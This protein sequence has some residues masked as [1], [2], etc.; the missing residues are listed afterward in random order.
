MFAATSDLF[1]QRMHWKART[2][3]VLAAYL[4]AA[5]LAAPAAA[6]P[7]AEALPADVVMRALSLLDVPYRYGGR[8]PEG[9]DCS[10]FVGFVYG[11][12]AG[13]ALP[14]RAEDL[15][16][17]GAERARSGLAPGDLVFFNTLG[18]S[19]SHVGIYIGDGRF[20]HAPARR[21]R[22]RIDQLAEPYWTARYNGARRLL[23]E[24]P[25]QIAGTALVPAAAL[26]SE[27]PFQEATIKP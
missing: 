26:S 3:R 8:G 13:M 6:Q 17:V 21:G 20:V 23:G 10:G 11:E 4:A 5:L 14:R 19:Y 12:A 9:F 16:R 18:R 2:K 24:P 1:G 15:G 27:S 25:A 7:A 22:V